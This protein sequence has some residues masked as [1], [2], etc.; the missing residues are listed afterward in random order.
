MNTEKFLNQIRQIIKEEVRSAIEN[1]FNILLESLDRVSNK[2]VSENTKITSQPKKFIP[3]K[4]R[5]ITPRKTTQTFSSNPIINEIL[6]DTAY[7]GFSSKDFH[8][9]L[10]EE[11]SPEM[12]GHNDYEEWPSMRNM[13]NLGMTSMPATAAMIPKTDIDG[14]PVHDVTPEVEQALTR[15]YSS[16]M[17][18]INKKKGA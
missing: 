17:K 7:S 6:N 1:E 4:S 14:R 2:V 9:I 5:T 11:Y 8:G 16:L 3:N 18:A 13:S 12:L 10:E 15:D